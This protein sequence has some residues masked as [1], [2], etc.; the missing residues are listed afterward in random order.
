MSGRTAQR[1]GEPD[2][3]GE[4]HERSALERIRNQAPS[5]TELF[6]KLRDGARLVEAP[7]FNRGLFVFN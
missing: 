4:T 6:T 1:K 5:H 3:T 7:N 2:E